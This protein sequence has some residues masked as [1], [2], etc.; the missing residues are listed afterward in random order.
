M[1][2]NY[3]QLL[4][5]NKTS[6]DA[7]IK[8]AY[9]RIIKKYPVDQYPEEFKT[10]RIAYDTLRNSQ[11]RKEYD[12]KMLHGDLVEQ[13][14]NEAMNA[15]TNDE[16]E[17]AKRL[18]KEVLTIVPTLT[19]TRNYYA[20]SF[21]FTEEYHQ[22][23]QHFKMVVHEEPENTTYQLN[24][25]RALEKCGKEEEAIRLY[26]KMYIMEPDNMDPLF[27]LIDLYLNRNETFNALKTLDQAISSQSKSGGFHAFYYLLKRI[28][29][30]VRIRNKVELMKSLDLCR[31]LLLKHESEQGNMMGD[32][33]DLGLDL[34]KRK[35][36]GYAKP[37]FEFVQKENSEPNEKFDSLVSETILRANVYDEFDLLERDER[38][39][40]YVKHVFILYLHGGDFTEDEFDRYTE[41]AYDNLHDSSV[42]NAEETLKSI[43]RVLIKYPNLFQER[44][45]VLHNFMETCK[46]SI[47]C[48]DEFEILK[49]DSHVC[50]PVKRLVAYY[51]IYFDSEDEKREMFA[52]IKDDF[53]D[54]TDRSLKRSIDRL[55]SRYPAL[56][57]LNEDFFRDFQ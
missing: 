13:L 22:A 44:E 35:L 16:F 4:E 3:Y 20:L 30:S 34:Y 57:G 51:L 49:N 8:R 55:E 32:L 15:Y 56:Y 26:K 14:K 45:K 48:H 10:I 9:F 50:H 11:T 25:G 7:D 18:F 6:T 27:Q 28:K 31:D 41:N 2:Q 42:Y 46:H 17:D 24:Y 33:T 37:I 19:E 47:Q 53:M 1:E 12:A 36:Y 29:V 21:L 40:D 54:E 39:I 52:S 38:V 5:I 43:K 23:L